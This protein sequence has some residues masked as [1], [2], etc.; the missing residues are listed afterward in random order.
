MSAPGRPARIAVVGASTAPHCGVRTQ[1]RKLAEGLQGNGLSCSW[2]WLQREP[3]SFADERRAF[4]AWARELERELA[5]ARPDAVLLH[6]SV[7]SYSHRGVPVF[8]PALLS[9]TRSIE[10]PLLSVMHELAY[11]WRRHGWRGATWAVTQRVALAAVVR[12]CSGIVVTAEG[13]RRWLSSRRWLPRRPI[14]VAPVFSNLPASRASAMGRRLAPSA[15][16]DRPP[17]PTVG[18][19]GYA[20]EGAGTSLV[21]DAVALL[22]DRGTPVQLRLLGAPGPDSAA[23]RA[24]LDGAGRRRIGEALSFSGV[25]ALGDLS[26]ALASCDVLLSADDS[27]PYPRKSTLAAALASGAPVVALDGPRTWRAV[28]D[29]DALALATPSAEGVADALEDLL[30]DPG[31]R[32]RLGARGRMFAEEH[33]S[34]T[35]TAA[36]VVGLLGAAARRSR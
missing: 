20:Y 7:F 21:L 35:R 16:F 10:A 9:A 36:V 4:E 14:D 24:W 27:G 12:A 28:V 13:R 18:L 33:M 3:G 19:F 17:R 5:D 11:P 34:V 26:D 23:G 29:A 2:H 30:R 1:A 15:D 8:V 6:Y 25:L 31:G 32:E 22:Y